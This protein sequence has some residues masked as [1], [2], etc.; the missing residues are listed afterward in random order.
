MDVKDLLVV[1][2]RDGLLL[3]SDVSL[4]SLV[5]LVVGGPIGGSWW[6]HPRG[7]DIYRL[8]NQ[9]ADAPSVLTVKL[10]SGKV[11]FVHRRL[12]PA[13]VAVG[14]SRESWQLDGLSEACTALLRLV[15]DVGEL[16]WDDVPRHFFSDPRSP[17]RAA[18]ELETRLLIHASEVH[19]PTGAHAKNLSTWAALADAVGLSP[20]Y[21]TPAEAKQQLE[22]ALADLSDRQVARA[23]LPWQPN[24]PAAPRLRLEARK[25]PK[26]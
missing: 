11:T 19:T 3:L 12:W 14:Q 7:G 15:D 26:T 5:S 23:R 6:G 10:V 17:T 25:L 21:P 20:P 8:Y 22:S 18:K 2:D 9:L 4:P 1:L 24:S 16:A 13:V